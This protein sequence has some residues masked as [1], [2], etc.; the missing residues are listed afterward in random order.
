VFSTNLCR[1]TGFD[2]FHPQVRAFVKEADC[3]NWGSTPAIQELR[4][5]DYIIVENH[6]STI[7]QGI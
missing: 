4:C 2:V 6:I 1:A 7:L 5:K 3:I